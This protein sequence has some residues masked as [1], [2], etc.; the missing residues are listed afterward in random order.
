[1]K[2]WCESRCIRG[3]CFCSRAETRFIASRLSRD[4]PRAWLHC[5]HTTPSP[6]RG[7]ASC[8]RWLAMAGRSRRPS[9]APTATRI[10]KDLLGA[11]AVPA[12]AL[13]GIHTVR[14]VENLRFSSSLLGN[15]PDYIRA[16]AMVKKA[17]ARANRDAHAIDAR[18]LGAIEYAC[19]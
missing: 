18:R 16:L 17:A 19:D 15:Y 5:W 14:A 8:C 2:A 12:D 3:R 1:M 4:A 11:L 6:Q 13:Y 10:E 7:V 9:R